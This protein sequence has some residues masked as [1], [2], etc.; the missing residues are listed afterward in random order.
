MVS[1]LEVQTDD[2]RSWNRMPEDTEGSKGGI[3]PTV[4]WMNGWRNGVAIGMVGRVSGR[5][6]ISRNADGGTLNL[7]GRVKA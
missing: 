5:Q 4:S 3:I 1:R 6:D 7:K 2:A